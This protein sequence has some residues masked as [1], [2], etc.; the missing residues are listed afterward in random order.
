MTRPEYIDTLLLLALP[1][2][3]KSEVRRFLLHAPLE[4]RIQQYHVADTVQL[5][6]FPYVH[7]LRCIDDELVRR[8]QA[9]VFYKGANTGFAN[10]LDWGTLLHLVNDDYAVMKDETTTTPGADPQ[11]L[12]ERI[13]QARAAVGAPAVFAGM[14]AELRDELAGALQGQ[15]DRLIGELF[16]P[17]PDSMKNQTLVIE[18]ARGGAEGASMPLTEPHGYGWNLSQLSP[19]LL[20]RA[21]ILYIW[22][23][24]EES[25]RKNAARAN[26]DDPGSI[27][28][29]SAPEE[30]LRADYGCDDIEHLIQQSDR[31]NTIRIEQDG[32]SF[33]LPIAVFDNRVDKTTFVRDD[34]SSWTEADIEALHGGLADPLERLWKAYEDLHN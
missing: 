15:T 20:E 9:P 29:H 5:D 6:D 27:L 11:R 4:R 3:G 8:D 31:P 12:F 30:V 26:P 21:A 33:Y 34:T 24:P 17:R 18:F 1:A 22:V 16:G 25:R 2:S 23:T 19:T 14:A 10:G 13:D 28:E 32:R 7:F